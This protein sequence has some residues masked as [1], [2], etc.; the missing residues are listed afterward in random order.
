MFLAVVSTI[1]SNGEGD[2]GL[3]NS[4]WINFSE[5]LGNI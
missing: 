2:G 3:G 5:K 4:R 1:V